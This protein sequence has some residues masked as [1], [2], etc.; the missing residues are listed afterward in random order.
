[1]GNV[2]ITPLEKIVGVNPKNKYYVFELSSHQLLELKKSP[3]IAV[4]LNIYREHLDYYESFEKYY[5]AK[6][7]IAKYQK[8]SDYFIYN[9]DFL[10]LKTFANSLISN[11]Y[12]FS[13]QNTSAKG[14]LKK[15]NLIVKY[16][17]NNT[18]KVPCSILSVIGVHNQINALAV[19]LV[20]KIVGVSNSKIISGIKT[21]KPVEHRLEKVAVI[22]GV[23]FINDSIC[24]LPESSIYAVD[25]FNDKD[26]TLICGGFDRGL[27]YENYARELEKRKNVK[28]IIVTGQT[29]TEMHKYLK[30]YKFK[31]K[32][33]LMPTSAMK[34]IVMKAYTITKPKGLVLLS[35]AAS[36][37]DKYK[38]YKDRGDQFKSA[39]QA[40]SV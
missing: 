18:L 36:S 2:G 6:Q 16:L 19:I 29:M 23:T 4:F 3:H 10:K 28:N 5:L 17:E 24:S 30:E 38:N 27:G 8:K 1:M 25:T 31:G 32:I 13:K 9:Y 35:A 12:S 21:F 15:D 14:Y 40:L 39:V 22:N 37:F 7:N 26:I 34:E 33:Y 20:T 11:T